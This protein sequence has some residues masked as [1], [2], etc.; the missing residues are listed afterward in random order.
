MDVE[1][2]A[3]LPYTSTGTLGVERLD[4]L[5]C[6]STFGYLRAEPADEHL[7]PFR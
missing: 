5:G 6:F 7:D 4:T 3:A 1:F 2:L